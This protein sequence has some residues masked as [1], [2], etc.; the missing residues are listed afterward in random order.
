MD[1]T[2]IQALQDASHKLRKRGVKVIFCEANER[3][4]GKLEKAGV[5]GEQGVLYASQLLAAVHLASDNPNPTK[6]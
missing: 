3:V 2:G 1:M 5:I 6:D 4:L